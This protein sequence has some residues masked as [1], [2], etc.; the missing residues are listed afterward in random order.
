M[1]IKKKTCGFNLTTWKSD[2]VLWWTFTSIFLPFPSLNRFIYCRN[3]LLSWRIIWPKY[4]SFCTFI[5]VDKCKLCV[6]MP[7][8]FQIFSPLCCVYYRPDFYLK[9]ALLTY[10]VYVIFPWLWVELLCCGIIFSHTSLFFECQ[11]W[12]PSYNFSWFYYLYKYSF[13]C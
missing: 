1:V 12:F 3:T 13:W 6:I 10:S 5:V 9:K 11:L 7:T 4:W 2:P 8:L